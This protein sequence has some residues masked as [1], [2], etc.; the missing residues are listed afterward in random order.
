MS[1]PYPSS[2]SV[3][4]PRPKGACGYVVERLVGRLIGMRVG[5]ISSF[6]DLD[7]L[8][9]RLLS[10][11]ELQTTHMVACCD[12]RGLRVL[13]DKSAASAVRGMKKVN[14]KLER[15]AV[16][17]P[18]ASSTLRLQMERLFR[19]AGNPARRICNDAAEAKAWLGSYLDA[20]ERAALDRFLASS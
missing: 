1:E 20:G 7:T 14:P 4:T 10:L 15:S 17:L 12:Y 16:L 3:K 19:D 18:S 5:E 2:V 11:V 8:T 13:D 6:D 9:R